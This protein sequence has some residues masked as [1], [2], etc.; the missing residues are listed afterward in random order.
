MRRMYL[1]GKWRWVRFNDDTG[2]GF[3]GPSW[4]LYLITVLFLAAA[5]LLYFRTRGGL[6][7]GYNTAS[8]SEKAMR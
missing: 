1:S 5:I 6:I 8:K 7:T 3:N 4:V 2:R